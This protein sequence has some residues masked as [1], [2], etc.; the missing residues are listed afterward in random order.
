[1]IYKTD[2]KQ[3]EC[4]AIED[5]F[6][7]IVESY[8]NGQLTQAKEQISKLSKDQKKDFIDY[9]DE[10]RDNDWTDPSMD[11]YIKLQDITIELI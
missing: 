7:L 10:C 8:I 6:N 4:N 9:L 5:Y 2:L 3:Y 1:M 11:S